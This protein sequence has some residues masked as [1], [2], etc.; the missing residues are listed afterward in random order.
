VSLPGFAEA[1][2]SEPNWGSCDEWSSTRGVPA[3]TEPVTS[4]VP[5]LVLVPGLAASTPADIVRRELAGWS[6][7]SLVVAPTMSD[8]LLGHA[9]V[10]ELRNQWVDDLQPVTTPDCI[11]ER[12]EW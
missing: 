3:P 8:N 9:C 6:D 11:E 10:Q 2:G 12:L 1:F 5:S 7:W 4:T